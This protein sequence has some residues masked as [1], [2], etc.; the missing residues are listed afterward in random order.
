M[1]QSLRC[2][3]LALALAA[4]AA[5]T[6]RAEQ[7]PAPP[8]DEAQQAACANCRMN[9]QVCLRTAQN[10]YQNLPGSSCMDQFMTCVD[11]QHIDRV[12]CSSF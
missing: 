11:A 1:R 7:P 6:P 4:C 2:A 3:C 8:L 12:R 10:G 5:K 9:L